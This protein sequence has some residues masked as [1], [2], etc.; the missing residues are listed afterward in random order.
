MAIHARAGLAL[1]AA[2]GSGVGSTGDG[3]P[4]MPRIGNDETDETRGYTPLD[5]VAREIQK[6]ADEIETATGLTLKSSTSSTAEND[7]ESEDP[8]KKK[9]KIEE[10][11][12][13]NRDHDNDPPPP[14]SKA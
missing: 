10:K 8:V 2:G 9:E 13:G 6:V 5:V 11:K 12:D 4:S 3:L 14:I 7:K 1:V